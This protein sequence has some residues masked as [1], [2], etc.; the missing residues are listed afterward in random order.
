MTDYTNLL[1]RLAV[2]AGDQE[3]LY[4]DA[5]AA[6][7]ALQTRVAEAEDT[8][9]AL[10]VRLGSELHEPVTTVEDRYN[11][12]GKSCHITDDLPAGMP[13]Y[14]A[15][16]VAAP[17][18][19]NDSELEMNPFRTD[20]TYHNNQYKLYQSNTW[21][22][23]NS[24]KKL[25]AAGIYAN[26]KDR[27]GLY[28]QLDALGEANKGPYG[29]VVNPIVQVG[30]TAV[31]NFSYRVW[32]QGNKATNYVTD[33]EQITATLS[34]PATFA[35]GSKTKTVNVGTSFGPLTLTG[36]GKVSA[37]LKTTRFP[38]TA[39]YRYYDGS[40]QTMVTKGPNGD[41]LSGATST[42]VVLTGKLKIKKVGVDTLRAPL[43]TYEKRYNR[44]I[45]S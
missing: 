1:E 32:N 15:P 28:A 19:P 38:S 6:I 11:A 5:K 44:L 40:T 45:I 22:T 8:N 16:P 34:G 41:S 37:S 26:E 36:N 3:C 9:K 7:E 33:R 13:L 43:K 39:L 18:R 29:L 27:T 10:R 30:N 24:I 20:I 35:D 42:D 14:A 23:D 2:S 17:V 21:E 12:D 4:A 25:S 31:A